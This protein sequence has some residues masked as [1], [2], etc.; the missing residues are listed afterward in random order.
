MTRC[1]R[2]AASPSVSLRQSSYSEKLSSKSA[3]FDAPSS[4]RIVLVDFPDSR[5]S[6]QDKPCIQEMIEDLLEAMQTGEEGR[7]RVRGHRFVLAGVCSMSQ[8]PP[9]R[10]GR[11]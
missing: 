6:L 2:S 9:D 10:A 7:R 8:A 1:G 5:I 3:T 4:A 11:W